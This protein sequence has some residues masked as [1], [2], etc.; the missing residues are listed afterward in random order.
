MPVALIHTG[1]IRNKHGRKALHFAP[2]ASCELDIDTV[3]VHFPV[4]DVVEPRPGHDRMAIF[5]AFGDREWKLIHA[6]D[7]IARGTLLGGR[8]I[9]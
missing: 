6:R 7:L 4:T 2:I 3:H 9:S 5:D 8:Q 1:Q